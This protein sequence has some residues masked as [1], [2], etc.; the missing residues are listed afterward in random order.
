MDIATQRRVFEPFF[1]TKGHGLGTGLG[2]STV[3]GIVKQSGGYIEVQSNAGEGSSFEIFL[4]RV[5]CEVDVNDSPEALRSSGK[6]ATILLAEDEQPVREAVKRILAG[7]GHRVIAATNGREALEYFTAHAQEVD[8][9][10]TD[11]VMPDMGGAELAKECLS[12][13]PL[14]GVLYMSGYAD[15]AVLTTDAVANRTRFIEKPFNREALLARL[16]ELLPE[17]G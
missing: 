9:L 1:S 17:R 11:I 15:A 3:Y 2:L 14:L 6:Q 7:E 12:Q 10:V 13:R 5:D 4:P 16:A 8:V